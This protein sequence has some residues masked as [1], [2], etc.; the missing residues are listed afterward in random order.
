M[1]SKRNVLFIVFALL[2]LIVFALTVTGCSKGDSNKV[3][4]HCPMHPTYISDKPGDCPICGMKLVPIDQ[5]AANQ[6]KSSP[7]VQHAPE[8]KPQAAVYTCPMHPQV[9]SDK[10][11]KCP[12]CGMDL[13]LKKQE[14]APESS[15]DKKILFY[16]NP[17]DPSIT[18]KTPMKDSM[19]MD[20]AP[21]YADETKTTPSVIEGLSPVTLS[22]SALNLAGVRTAMAMREKLGGVIRT[23]GIVTADERR[24]RRVHTKVSGYIEKLYV[25]FTGQPVQKGQ[26]IIGI[27]SPELLASQQEYL[28]A[29]ETAKGFSKSKIEDVQ[30]GGKELVAA[31]KRRLELFDVPQSF[32][33][34]LGQSGQPQRT[35][36]LTAPFSGYATVKNIYEG[37][38]VDPSM[39]LFAITDLSSVWIDAD[40]YEYEAHSVKVG[41]EAKITLPYDPGVSLTGK[42]SFVY[43]TLNPDS[44][45]LKVRFDAPNKDI[46]LKPD[47]YANVQ[48]QAQAAD[49]VVFPDSA[50]MDTGSRQ[51]VFVETAP[52]TFEPREVHVTNRADGKVQVQSGVEAGDKVVVHANFL[53]DSESRLKAA[54]AEVGKS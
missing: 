22:E 6:G 10:P 18:S 13:V 9:I 15:A 27:Y 38:Q 16:R 11:G 7:D 48:L 50:V 54:I 2:L 20:Y 45:T 37:Q 40:F 51:I 31:A 43:P 14:P 32:I 46:V 8:Q 41:Q 23:V 19:G 4:Y 39:E 33:A 42:V 1:K 52:G 17:M 29:V 24:I 49:G 12:I 25:N 3:L 53:L 47:M 5:S 44:R 36:T 21:V 35:I 26:A 34:K 30:S 28:R